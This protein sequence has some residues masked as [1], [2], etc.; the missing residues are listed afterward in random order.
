MSDLP[1]N[2]ELIRLFHTDPVLHAAA[3]ILGNEYLDGHVTMRE[4]KIAYVLSL[5][6]HDTSPPE[7]DFGRYFLHKAQEEHA[8]EEHARRV[9][10]AWRYRNTF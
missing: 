7:V 5:A 1:S 8:Q 10:E 6:F 3:T 2:A 4:V 9:R